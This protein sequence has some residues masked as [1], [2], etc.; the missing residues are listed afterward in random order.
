MAPSRHTP[1]NLERTKPPRMLQ[2]RALIAG[3]R[4]G[5]QELI[6]DDRPPKVR[7][8]KPLVPLTPSPCG[9]PKNAFLPFVRLVGAAVAGFL[10]RRARIQVSAPETSIW[11]RALERIVW[12]RARPATINK[13]F[14][15]VPTRSTR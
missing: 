9:P 10:R 2:Q 4:I 7:L 14:H 1:D 6:V 12:P 15:I 8:G 5:T 13:S 11:R 3:A